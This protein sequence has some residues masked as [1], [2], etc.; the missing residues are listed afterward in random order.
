MI[1]RGMCSER[2]VTRGYGPGYWL[3]V[4]EFIVGVSRVTRN[5]VLR[6]RVWKR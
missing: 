5:L 1:L 3:A 6:S 2:L 4:R